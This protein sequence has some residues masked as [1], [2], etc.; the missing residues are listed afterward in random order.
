MRNG[1]LLALVATS[2]VGCGSPGNAITG[3]I[4]VNDQPL[5]GGYIT[6][7]PVEGT[8][9]IKGSP[10]NDGVFAISE[11]PA[12]KWKAL[13]S[14]PPDVQAVENNNGSQR[15]VIA[16]S[17]QSIT[18]MTKG[19]QQIVEIRPGKQKLEFALRTP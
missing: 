5:Q 13:I 7:Y 9:G 11:L 3:T 17:R 6:F 16:R 12:G 19:N 1:L 2:A 10:V 15:L 14:E 8:K 4:T 18:P